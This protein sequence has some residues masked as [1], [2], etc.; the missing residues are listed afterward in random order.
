MQ[1]LYKLTAVANNIEARRD[2]QALADF[3]AALGFGAEAADL[4]PPKSA[5]WRKI[6]KQIDALKSAMQSVGVVVPDA[7]DVADI[8]YPDA[9]GWADDAG[10][11]HHQFCGGCG[12]DGC[13]VWRKQTPGGAQ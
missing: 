12:Q 7:P 1:G 8:G 6:D 11:W 13:I 3:A 9:H 2:W 4:T 10:V 5:G